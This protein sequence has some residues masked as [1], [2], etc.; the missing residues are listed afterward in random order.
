MSYV[1]PTLS[2]PI[3]HPPSRKKNR[4]KWWVDDEDRRENLN[5]LLQ[6]DPTNTVNI[7]DTWGH[8]II[9]DGLSGSEHLRQRITEDKKSKLEDSRQRAHE[10]NSESNERIRLFISSIR[11]SRKKLALDKISVGSKYIPSEEE[12]T[13]SANRPKNRANKN[14]KRGGRSTGPGSY[15]GKTTWAV[16]HFELGRD[17]VITTTQEA[18]RD[19]KEKLASRLGADASS[20]VKTMVSVLVNGFQE[21]NSCD[22]LIIDEALMSHFGAIVMATW[23]AGAKE[24]LLISDVNQ[25]P[26]IERLNLFEMHYIRPNLVAMVTKELLCTYRHPMDSKHM[27]LKSDA[28]ILKDLPNTLYLTYTQ[29]EKESLITW[30]FGKGEGTR[31]LT[32]HEAQGLTS[33]RTVTVQIVAKHKLHDSVSHAIVAITRYAVSCLYHIDNGE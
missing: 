29:V 26:F 18:E 16:K 4:T 7:V 8:P 27:P 6:R 30:G 32:V 31:I 3:H 19:F 11:K 20:K 22:R 28:N 14:P 17:V 12:K 33:E 13:N 24:V 2:L 23:L 21:L 1:P 9:S 25:V 10:E 15:C 5:Y